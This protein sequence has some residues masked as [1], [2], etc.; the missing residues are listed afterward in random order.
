M[1]SPAPLRLVVSRA[2]APFRI[3][4]SLAFRPA[5]PLAPHPGTRPLLLAAVAA[6]AVHAA[7]LAFMMAGP[8]D[9]LARSAGAAE[10]LLLIEGIPVELV[11]SLPT[12]EAPPAEAAAEPETPAEP[13]EMEPVEEPPPDATPGVTE[14]VVEPPPAEPPQEPPPEPRVEPPQQTPPEPID[15]TLPPAEAETGDLPARPE[16]PV[17]EPPPEEPPVTEPPPPVE[18]PPLEEPPPEEIQPE[19]PPPEDVEPPP[20]DPDAV[21]PP[22]PR[23]DRPEPAETPPEPPKPAAPPPS[24]PTAASSAA[25]SGGA[26]GGGAAQTAGTAA[27]SAYRAKVAAQLARKKFYPN[28]ARRDRLTGRTTVRFILNAAGRVTAVKVVRS[29]GS[30]ILDDAAVEMVRGAAP[31][32]PIPKGLGSTITIQAP[33]GFELPR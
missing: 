14:E 8:R 21:P 22:R 12:P 20:P 11:E 28:A 31:Y 18:E 4:P 16:V 9:D 1:S 32:P 30:R 29:A 33:I 5:P 24:A 2:E 10:D 7:T 27:D 3:D 19:E 6:F 25:R 13:V 15:D 26:G 17:A 23:P